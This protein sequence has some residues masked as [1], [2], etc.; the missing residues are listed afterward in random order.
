MECSCSEAL[1]LFA[2]GLSARVLRAHADGPLEVP[3][4]EE[5]LAWAPDSSV[6]AAVKRLCDL[7]A[8]I[9][10]TPAKGSQ[11]ATFEVTDAG[12]EL[13]TVADALEQW[14]E[15][16][17]GGP[18]ALDAPAAQGI[19]KALVAGWDSAIVRTLAER[20]HALGELSAAIA[21]VSYP[22]LKRRLAK[23]R[24]I[25][26]IVPISD[27]NGAPYVVSDWLCQVVPPLLLAVRWE[28]RYNRAADAL[29]ATEAEAA[30]LL[31][32]RLVDLPA[33]ASGLCALAMLLSSN[34]GDPRRVTTVRLEVR[35]GKVISCGATNGTQPQTWALGN[36]EAWFASLVDGDSKT[37]RINGAHAR[38]A[39]TVVESLH[40]T[41][42]ER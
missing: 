10:V 13:L 38:L 3:H 21:G 2:N 8:L 34:E 6:R 18:L 36:L 28:R 9:E 5:M 12:R 31:G 25:G 7:R 32:L 39:E 20:P 23:L 33:A 1:S 41:L 17:P 30:F 24:S 14:L 11:A 19:V 35:Q 16:A 42:F 15:H 40:R 26:L 29:T 27:E 22:S 37:L 4:L